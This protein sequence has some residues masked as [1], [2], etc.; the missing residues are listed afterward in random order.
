MGRAAWLSETCL[1]RD[2]ACQ[3]AK[4]SPVMTPLKSLTI[5]V[6]Q[7]ANNKSLST[8]VVYMVITITTVVD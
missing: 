1:A 4:M 7:N 8:S 2:K 5:K 3:M 6:S